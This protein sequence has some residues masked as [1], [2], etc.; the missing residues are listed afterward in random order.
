MEIEDA[1]GRQLAVIKK[2]LISS[3]RG[4]WVV[5]VRNDPELDVQGSILDQQYSIK[6][7][8]RK[9]AEISKKWF[10]PTDTYGVELCRDKTEAS[11]DREKR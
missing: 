7:G 9:I 1:E 6:Q 11:V 4:H 2:A 8:R 10:L 3:L 5:N